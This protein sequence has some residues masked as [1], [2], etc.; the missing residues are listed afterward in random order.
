MPG[1]V[2]GFPGQSTTLLQRAFRPG[3]LSICLS[4]VLFGALWI[5]L[6]DRLVL[7]MV[8]PDAEKLIAV[9]IGKGWAYII[10]SGVL[11]YGLVWRRDRSTSSQNQL[12]GSILHSIGD[13]VI[14]ADPEGRVTAMNPAAEDLFGGVRNVEELGGWYARDGSTPLLPEG[15]P[16]RHGV[17]GRATSRTVVFIRNSRLPAG[18]CFSVTGRPILG[19]DGETTGVVVVLHD[20]TALQM[21]EE[22]IRSSESLFH[23]LARLAPV[24]IFRCDAQGR[25]IYVNERW[26]E[27]AGI[28]PM[29]A[30]DGE[31]WQCAHPDDRAAVAHQWRRCSVSRL[32]CRFEFRYLRPDGRI[33]WLLAETAEEVNAAQEV[34]GYVGTVTDMTERKAADDNTRRLADELERRV[35]ERTAQLQASTR[36]LDAFSYSVSHDLRAPLRT[37]SGFSQLVLEESRE[38]LSE[39]ARGHLARVIGATRRMGEIIDGL[40]NLAKVTRTHLIGEWVD[41]SALAELIFEDLRGE[42]PERGLDAS[43]AP[44]IRLWGDPILL[45]IA[46]ENLVRNAWKFTRRTP[47]ARVWIEAVEGEP[48]V[49]VSDNGAGFDMAWVD[50]LFRAFE[51]LHTDDE[52]PGSGIG[53]ATVHRIVTRHGGRIWASGAVGEGASFSF[54]VLPGPA[55]GVGE[56]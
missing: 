33:G 32:P 14:V 8:G 41:M 47:G 13:G 52:F 50:K 17:F 7:A 4:Y 2:R 21:A 43:V 34:V 48:G 3:P 46:L 53:L 20:V 55:A 56:P 26:C 23:S 44:D 37:I 38:G 40:L 25:C 9:S 30:C 1:P 6:S 39:P 15:L 35:G 5:L 54:T 10:G 51:R 16:L 45:R 28:T 42:E 11:L 22:R 31:W 27:L 49:T 18:G 19:R 12:L 29:A 36:E 24:G